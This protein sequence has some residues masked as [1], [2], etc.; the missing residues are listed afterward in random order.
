MSQWTPH[1]NRLTAKYNLPPG[2]IGAVM[3]QESG[4]QPQV[5]SSAGAY[6]LMQLMPGTARGL[7]V[8]PTDPLQNLE[9]GAKYLRQMLDMFGGS[10]PKAL[11]AYNAGPGAVKKYGGIPPY[12]QTQ[13]YVPKVMGYMREAGKG[14]PVQQSGVP[15]TAPEKPAVPL[16]EVDPARVAKIQNAWSDAPANG[17]LRVEREYDKQAASIAAQPA[18]V[19]PSVYGGPTEPTPGA[20]AP[21]GYYRTPNGLVQAQREGEAGWQFMQRLGTKGFGLQNDPGNSQTYGGQHAAGSLHGWDSPNPIADGRAI[22]FGTARNSQSLL[23]QWYSWLNARRNPIGIAELINEG[24]H[25][26]AGLR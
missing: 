9:G 10:I 4:G 25:I 16:Y 19:S 23:N 5:R 12:S 13:E 20:P 8:D 6:G 14:A 2:L 18:P 24:D 26:H 1:I 11:A 7:G 3:R 15:P 22:D 21:G 17:A